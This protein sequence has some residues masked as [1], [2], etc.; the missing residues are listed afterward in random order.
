MSIRRTLLSTLLAAAVAISAGLGM[1]PQVADD[2]TSLSFT[3]SGDFSSSAAARSVFAGIGAAD[4]DLHL[5]VGD[6]S[7]GATG[8]EAAWC[9]LVT[10]HVGAGF[11]F[12][13]LAGNHESN[14]QNGNINDFSA[15]LPNQLPGLVGTYGRQY[16]VDVPQTAP[17]VRFVMISPGVPYTGGEWRYDRGTARYDWTAAAIDGARSEGIPWVVVGMHMPC[18]SI[19]AYPCVAGADVTNL[20]V[21][22]RVDL[23]LS[24][25]EHMYQRTHQL[26]TGAGCTAIVPGTFNAGCVADTDAAMVRGAGTVFA[27]VGTG[28]VSF[29]DIN[30]ADSEAGYVAA[31]AGANENPT[32]GSLRVDATATRLSASFARTMGGTLTDEF[33]LGVP[34]PAANQPPNAQFTAACSALTCTFDGAGS[35]DSD[36]LLANYAWD[37]GDGTVADGQGPSASHTYATAGART[38]R[39]TVTDDD[40]ATATTTRTVNPTAPPPAGSLAADDFQRTTANGWGSAPTGGAWTLTGSASRFSVNNGRGNMLFSAGTQLSAHLPSVSST[41][42]DVR[43][44]VSSDKRSTGGSI[45][46]SVDGRQIAGVGAYRAKVVVNSAGQVTLA[47]VRVNATGAET[48]VQPATVVSGITYTPGTKLAV[49]IRV[50]GTGPTLLQARVWPAAGTEPTTWHRAGTDTTSALQAPGAVGL[51]GYLSGGVTNAPVT[52]SFD[53]LQARTP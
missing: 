20:L 49:R 3:A 13:L 15:C 18:L 44:D 32:W 27:T 10:S 35:S 43:V 2:A 11:P 14:G 5:A 25:H 16:Y 19:G 45:Y 46:V 4:V 26:R 30:R 8:E 50:T 37:F 29:R 28:G 51:L 1:A 41:A 53:D 24:G 36:G 21:E 17:L 22:K 34:D 48:V 7:Y 40:G 6:L 31:A 12:E 9:D 38:V 23:V 39:L 33:T 47:L 42:T 52:L